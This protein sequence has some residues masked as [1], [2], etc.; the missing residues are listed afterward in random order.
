MDC[1]RDAEEEFQNPFRA[2]V[3]RLHIRHNSFV[4]GK[5]TK[6]LGQR[7]FSFEEVSVP[8]KALFIRC[9]YSLEA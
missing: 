3:K 1:S 7:H 5:L 2:K 9:L 8:L 6:S 4:E